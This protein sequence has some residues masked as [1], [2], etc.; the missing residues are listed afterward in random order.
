MHD[1]SFWQLIS[2]AA[3]YEF[4]SL[5][6]GNLLIAYVVLGKSI[7][8]KHNNGSV[9]YYTKIIE[10]IEGNCYQFHFIICFL[11]LHQSLFS[12]VFL[13]RTIFSTSTCHLISSHSL[14][15]QAALSILAPLLVKI[16]PPLEFLCNDK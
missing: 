9:S 13:C 11:N 5:F 16:S 7:T 1:L 12:L 2:L 15:Y 4:R 3:G 10:I 14:Q 6:L 8:A